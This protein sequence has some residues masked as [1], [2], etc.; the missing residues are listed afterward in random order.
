M[1]VEVVGLGIEEEG[2]SEMLLPAVRSARSGF[3]DR[4]YVHKPQC[5]QYPHITSSFLS[6]GF[7]APPLGDRTRVLGEHCGH[8][9]RLCC[10][11]QNHHDLISEATRQCTL[12]IYLHFSKK[13][14]DDLLEHGWEATPRLLAACGMSTAWQII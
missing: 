12:C 13:E 5:T 8:N 3:E 9:S 4:Q 14:C 7:S 6:D 10:T 2:C 1:V 11:T